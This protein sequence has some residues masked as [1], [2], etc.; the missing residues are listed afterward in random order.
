MKHE[1]YRIYILGG[2]A[3]SWSYGQAIREAREQGTVSFEQVIFVD[4]NADCVA[5]T[6]QSQNPAKDWTWLA[7]APAAFLARYLR[8]Y[9]D[10]HPLD[11]VVPD[12]TA[13]HVMLQ[14]YLLLLQNCGL[15]LHVELQA[16]PT[17]PTTPFLHGS[18]GHSVWAMSHAQWT[19][20]TDCDEPAHCPAIDSPRAWD[21]NHDMEQLRQSNPTTH[22]SEFACEAF[23]GPISHMP[24]PMLL[25]EVSQFMYRVQEHW[26]QG[27]LDIG[28]VTHSHCHGIVG[29]LR[30]ST[31]A[32]FAV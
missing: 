30:V 2:H 28:V 3:L 17:P 20:P 10:A 13:K 5:A 16:L 15:P 7:M 6:Q 23:C 18:D 32:S 1:F 25:R 31:D 9:N 4:D 24:A 26:T 22:W 14:T 8:K 12:H 27:P 21:M 19:C 11:T 29:H